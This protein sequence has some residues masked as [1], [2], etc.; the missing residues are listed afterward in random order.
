LKDI[1]ILQSGSAAPKVI[2]HGHAKQ[3]ATLLGISSIKVA[4]S[5]SGQYAIAQAVAR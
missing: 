4:I 3:V 2:L 1:E 5:H